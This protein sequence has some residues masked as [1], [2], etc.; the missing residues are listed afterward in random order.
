ISI[1]G[2]R[3]RAPD[4]LVVEGLLV[5]VNRYPRGAVPRALLHRDLLS[6]GVDEAVALGG[7]EAA[8]LDVRPLRADR[9][10]LGGRV[11][12]ED[13]PVAVEVGLALVPVARILLA[14]PVR[15]LDVLDEHKR[16]A[17]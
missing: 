11:L 5:L 2:E 13:R 14:D 9:R 7:R 6:E 17:P 16:A 1:Q 3:Q 15:A 10:D 8:E 12:H 4:A